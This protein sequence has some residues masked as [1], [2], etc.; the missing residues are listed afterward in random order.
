MTASPLM[1]PRADTLPR[2]DAHAGQASPAAS[3]ARRLRTVG[4]R[5]LLNRPIA[6]SE[7]AAPEARVSEA[8]HLSPRHARLILPTLACALAASAVFAAMTGAYAIPALAVLEALVAQVLGLFTQYTPSLVEPQHAAVLWSI[9]L[10]R[11]LMAIAVGAALGV[12]GAL[13]QGLFRNPLADAGLIGVSSGAALAAA[14]V[15]V[16]GGPIANRIAPGFMPWLLPVAGFVGGAL[17]LFAIRRLASHEGQT[18]ITGMLL[19][20]VAMT[21]LAGAGIGLLLYLAS[22]SQ[23]REWTFWSLGSLARADAGIALGMAAVAVACTLFATR[24]ARA[25]DALALGER[26]A[27]QLGVDV[28]RLKRQVTV[29]ALMATGAA[30]AFTGAIGFVGLVAPHMV[31]L[32]VGPAHGLLIP[33][34]ALLGAILLVLADTVARVIAAPAEL[35]IGI[36]TALLGVPFFVMLLRRGLRGLHGV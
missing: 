26:E 22:D 13:L 31:R 14:A 1:S 29:L 20:G 10:P 3:L 6:R 18:S 30:V 23:N 32:A 4:W 8:A 36:L 25:L 12:S 17:V 28:E 7:V 9:R 11:V 19:A 5:G 34:S 33:A 24:L 16:L 15:I 21:A 27:L 35:P 2:P